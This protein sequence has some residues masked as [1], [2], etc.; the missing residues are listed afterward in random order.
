MRPREAYHQR[1]SIVP[2]LRR[3]VELV[4]D[5]SVSILICSST[6][7]IFVLRAANEY[8][9]GLK[10][11]LGDRNGNAMVFLVRVGLDVTEGGVLCDAGENE[12]GKG[13]PFRPGAQARPRSNSLMMTTDL[14]RSGRVCRRA[15]TERA[16]TPSI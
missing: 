9:E 11:S 8:G 13:L 14:I 15:I 1:R 12:I 3:W 7:K 2:F 16:Q 4:V 6:P 5:P 10:A